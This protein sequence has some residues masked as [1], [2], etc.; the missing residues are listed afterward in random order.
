MSNSKKMLKAAITK[1]S[2]A[3]GISILAIASFSG[4]VLKEPINPLL[5]TIIE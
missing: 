2:F 4:L 3:V 1:M 5:L